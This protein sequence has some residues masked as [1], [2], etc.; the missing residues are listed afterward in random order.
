MKR[1]R[2]EEL[3]KNHPVSS[4]SYRRYVDNFGEPEG[5]SALALTEALLDQL[6]LESGLIRVG[7]EWITVAESKVHEA[8]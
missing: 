6:A 8:Q 7:E 2:F 3:F 4:A 5:L 1:E